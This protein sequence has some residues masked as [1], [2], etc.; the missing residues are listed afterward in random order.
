MA[1]SPSSGESGINVMERKQYLKELCDEV[2]EVVV[3]QSCK[4]FGVSEPS[5]V[6]LPE[7]RGSGWA[8]FYRHSN[9]EVTINRRY[10]GLLIHEVAHHITKEVYGKIRSNGYHIHH[11]P[12][13]KSVV[14]ELHDFWRVNQ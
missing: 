7:P 1:K 6:L 5:V 10:M 14:Q 13:Y 12:E 4:K 8:G 9:K 2:I 3:T 11:G